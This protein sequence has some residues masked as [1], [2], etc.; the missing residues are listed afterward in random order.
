MAQYG[1]ADAASKID[2]QSRKQAQYYQQ[3]DTGLDA[4]LGDAMVGGRRWDGM[5]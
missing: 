2:E 4:L 5:G 1:H 3:L